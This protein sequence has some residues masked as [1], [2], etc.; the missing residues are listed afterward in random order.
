M[1]KKR[2]ITTMDTQERYFQN[3]LGHPS[4][5]TALFFLADPRALIR[6]ISRGIA[7]CSAAFF[8]PAKKGPVCG[9]LNSSFLAE[10]FRPTPVSRER[11]TA[12][13]PFNPR[14]KGSSRKRSTAVPATEPGSTSMIAGPV[15]VIP[16]ACGR[17]PS[18]PLVASDPRVWPGRCSVA[19]ALSARITPRNLAP[20]QHRLRCRCCCRG[21]RRCLLFSRST[22][23]CSALQVLAPV[24]VSRVPEDDRR[25][26]TTDDR[27]RRVVF[28]NFAFDIIQV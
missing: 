11:S 20:L 22:Y 23:P 14:A 8:V 2:K 4:L 18:L 21:R 24:R 28:G 5:P 17:H 3:S 1:R 26:Q 12:V 25:R 27:R 13:S 9:R 15:A 19:S 7:C 6:S 16:L 10:A